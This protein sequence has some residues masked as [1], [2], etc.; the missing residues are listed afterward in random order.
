MLVVFHFSF[1]H[2]RCYS[3]SHCDMCPPWSHI[4]QDMSRAPPGS[5]FHASGLLKTEVL[6]SCMGMNENRPLYIQCYSE[7][8]YQLNLLRSV[9][10]IHLTSSQTDREWESIVCSDEGFLCGVNQSYCSNMLQYDSKILQRARPLPWN[11]G[12]LTSE[13]STQSLT[14]D[15]FFLRSAWRMQKKKKHSFNSTTSKDA[16]AKLM[17]YCRSKLKVSYW[18]LFE[19]TEVKLL[20][21][22]LAHHIHMAYNI[23]ISTGSLVRLFC[24]QKG[25]RNEHRAQY[26][27]WPCSVMPHNII[28]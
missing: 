23:R 8:S 1:I 20:C 25:C 14:F 17:R 5:Q 7:Q 24:D 10:D 9:F 26:V 27:A 2:Q 15:L 4:H 22:G 6:Q 16:H 13:E 28:C 18:F 21:G 12:C 19:Y 3:P 11:V